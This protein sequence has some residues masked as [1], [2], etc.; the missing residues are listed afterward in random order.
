[1]GE[2]LRDRGGVAHRTGVGIGCLLGTGIIALVLLWI[3][4]VVLDLL[5][6]VV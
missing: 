2:A 4:T 1:M 6:V 5:G 3:L